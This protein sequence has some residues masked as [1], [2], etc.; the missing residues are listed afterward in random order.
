MSKRA[1][2]RQN[3]RRRLLPIAALLLLLAGVAMRWFPEFF[4]DGLWNS[5]NLIRMA[6]GIFLA[7]FAAL[8]IFRVIT[9]FRDRP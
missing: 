5:I 7:F 1:T 2:S 8:V 6:G 3:T 4:F 9:V